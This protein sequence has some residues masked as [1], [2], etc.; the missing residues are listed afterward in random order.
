MKEKSEGNQEYMNY[1]IKYMQLKEKYGKLKA[2]NE[3]VD[4]SLRNESF[5]V[6]E[7]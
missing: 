5:R 6:L 1:H 7:D 2:E 3:V 4:L